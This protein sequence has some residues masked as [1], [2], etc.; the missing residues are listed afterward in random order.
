MAAPVFNSVELADRGAL[1]ALQ[2]RRLRSQLAYLDR[3]SQFYRRRFAEEGIAVDGI[4]GIADLSRIAFTTKQDLRDSL[5]RVRPLGEHLAARL[6]DVVQIQA[7]SG[8]T[9]SPSYVGLTERCGALRG[10]A[11]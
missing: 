7:S 1:R 2:E 4:A 11:V 3:N 10:Q 6:E 8:T 5:A 9:G